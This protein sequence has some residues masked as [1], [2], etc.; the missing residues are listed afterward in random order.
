MRVVVVCEDVDDGARVG[1]DVAVELPRVAQ[2]VGEQPFVGA[3]RHPVD[4]IVCVRAARASP[5]SQ[6]RR[7]T[8]A[9][10]RRRHD[11][12]PASLK[13]WNPP[14]HAQ[15]HMTP[16]APPSSTLC[17]NAGRY[18]DARSCAEMVES[19][20]CRLSEPCGPQSPSSELAARRVHRRRH[21]RPSAPCAA[22]WPSLPARAQA[23]TRTSTDAHKHNFT[24]AHG[25]AQ[26]QAQRHAHARTRTSPRRASPPTIHVSRST[27][28]SAH[29][30]S[31]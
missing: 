2:R 4:R 24:D 25:R 11:R 30:Q 17:L 26:A 12:K 18:V 5:T 28:G 27:M 29:R 8:A 9:S 23:R 6:P 31:A 3:R 13:G 16:S 7:K 21:G 15:E 22:S 19:T 1:R 10:L 14:H 20:V